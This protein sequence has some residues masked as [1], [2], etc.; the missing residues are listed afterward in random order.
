MQ[1]GLLDSLGATTGHGAIDLLRQT[2]VKTTVHTDRRFVDYARVVRSAEVLRTLWTKA[3]Q[4]LREA[5]AA[6]G[7]PCILSRRPSQDY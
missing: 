3:A 2:A 7:L 5:G 4:V 1:G 6:M